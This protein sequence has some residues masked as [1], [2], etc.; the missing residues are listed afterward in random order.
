M[1]ASLGHAQEPWDNPEYI[2]PEWL[3]AIQMHIGRFGIL[4]D[5]V[6]PD[7]SIGGAP[8]P[9]P[10]PA[11]MMS[12]PNTPPGNDDDPPPDFFRSLSPS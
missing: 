11:M 2:S 4:Q 8:S 7:N 5:G 6:E 9:T 12:P 1:M 10:P 3:K